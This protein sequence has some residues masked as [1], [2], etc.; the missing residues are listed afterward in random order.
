MLD[1]VIKND[2]LNKAEWFEHRINVLETACAKRE[3]RITQLEEEVI[4]VR[5][6]LQDI[7]QNSTDQ[8]VVKTANEALK[9]QSGLYI[10]R[11]LH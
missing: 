7:C 2:N 5:K 6:A 1:D 8:E 9:T 11:R 3:R 10:N 4:R